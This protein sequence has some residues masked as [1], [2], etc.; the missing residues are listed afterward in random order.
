MKK[1]AL[2]IVLA[3]VIGGAA[4][5]GG[6]KY[7]GGSNLQANTFGQGTRNFSAMRSGTQQ[8]EGM[9]AGS[10]QG[11]RAQGGDML[12]GEILSADDQSLTV[13]LRDGGSKIVFFSDLTEITKSVEGGVA[14]LVEGKTVMVSG[15]TNS[16]GSVTAKVIQLRP[17]F[18]QAPVNQDGAVRQ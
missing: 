8:S 4:F 5:Y 17:D 7:A 14:D 15:T 12:N 1:T 3:L 16:D 6:M 18:V 11:L 10:F 13:K 9:I 2:Y